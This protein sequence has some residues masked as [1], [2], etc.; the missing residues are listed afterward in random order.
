VKANYIGI[1]VIGIPVTL[2]TYS[3]SVNG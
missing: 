1:P 2:S 3:L